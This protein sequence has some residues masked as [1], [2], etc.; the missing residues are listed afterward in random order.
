MK[1]HKT[2]K[3]R[4][5]CNMKHLFLGL[6]LLSISSIA[7]HP[8][9]ADSVALPNSK[10]AGRMLFMEKKCTACHTM[11]DQKEGKRTPVINLGE[12]DWFEEHIAENSKIVLRQEKRKRRIA[13]VARIEN[14]LL[15]SWISRSS[16]LEKKKIEALPENIFKGAYMVARH[17]CLSC[18]PLAGEG[19]D[20][21]PELDNIGN[22]HTR[23]WLLQKL[24][25]PEAT[26]P[27][28]E[29]KSYDFLSKEQLNLLVDYLMTL[30]KP[31]N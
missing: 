4:K 20:D 26:E 25:D 2:I 15:Q 24:I 7:A 31:V 6:Y 27:D 5:L 13:R 28:T 29:M 8:Q 12:P 9:A 22:E 23:K 21:A 19:T 14:N 1:A 3:V 16:P 10:I 18:H 30:K 17:K 11:T